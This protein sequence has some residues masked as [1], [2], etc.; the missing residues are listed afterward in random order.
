MDSRGIEVLLVGQSARSSF[1]LLQWLDNQ[2]CQCSFASTY[3]DACTLI[4]QTAFDLVISQLELPDRT[5]Y[6]LL[7][8]LRGSTA[9]LFFSKTL[10]NGCLWLPMLVRGRECAGANALRPEEFRDML[11]KTLAFSAREESASRS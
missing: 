7:D 10:E 1:Q 9:T 2:G 5:A 4:S 8:W 3:R 11:G 6:P